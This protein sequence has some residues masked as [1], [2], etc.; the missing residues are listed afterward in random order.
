MVRALNLRII[1]RIRSTTAVR[2][3]SRMFSLKA[4]WTECNPHKAPGQLSLCHNNTIHHAEANSIADSLTAIQSTQGTFR[5]DSFY[6]DQLDTVTA[7]MITAPAKG[8]RLLAMT[9]SRA[10]SHLK[11]EKVA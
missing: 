4:L 7:P 6:L 3:V 1:N 5:L 9:K 8:A 2:G 11:A 10:L